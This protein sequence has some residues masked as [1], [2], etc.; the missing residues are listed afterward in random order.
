MPIEKDRQFVTDEITKP[1]QSEW[2]DPDMP[3]WHKRELEKSIQ[4]LQ[5]NP[6]DFVTWEYVKQ[7]MLR[8]KQ[9]RAK[10]RHR[11]RM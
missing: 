5:T 11:A 7:E 2:L 9:L 3:E 6:N 1:L 4:E 8:R 10:S